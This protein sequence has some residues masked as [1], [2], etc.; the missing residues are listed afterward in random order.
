[1][2]HK[3]PSSDKDKKRKNLTWLQKIVKGL[4]EKDF[5]GEFVLVFQ[6]GEIKTYR[7]IKTGKPE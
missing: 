6:K 7:E 3:A 1:M 4:Q 2:E 5:Y